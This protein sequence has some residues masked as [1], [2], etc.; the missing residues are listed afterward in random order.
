M[1][2]ES[3]RSPLKETPQRDRVGIEVWVRHRLPDSLNPRPPQNS[4]VR[5]GPLHFQVI[6]GTAAAAAILVRL[7]LRL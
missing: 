6:P 7:S 5:A 3:R 4:R 1:L 2:N